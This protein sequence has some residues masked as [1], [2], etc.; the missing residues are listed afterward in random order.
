MPVPAG[1]VAAA[2]TGCDGWFAGEA[3]VEVVA[4]AGAGV[5]PGAA[6]DVTVADITFAV[7]FGA[8]AE[9]GV[10]P[11]AALVVGVDAVVLTGDPV[12]VAAWFVA[13]PEGAA[14]VV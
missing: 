3:V 4:T 7:T 12:E 6:G 13:A 14:L 11:V 2:V 8:P 1:E 5:E 9:L 10:D